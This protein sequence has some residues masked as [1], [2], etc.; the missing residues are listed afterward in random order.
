[1]PLAAFDTFVGVI[2]TDA[3]GFLDGFH[4]LRI[5]DS[6]A[7]V[8]VFADPPTLGLAQRTVDECPKAPTAKLT[9][10]IIDC[11][12]R[13]EIAG[14]IA[15]RTARAKQIKE[16]IEDRAKGMPSESPMR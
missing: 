16:S 9:P 10:M 2:P 7:W 6:C 14:Q 1:M 8:R 11:L 12:P 13:R 15:P 3:T 4:T 5:H